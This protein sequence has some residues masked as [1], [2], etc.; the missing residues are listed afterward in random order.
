MAYSTSKFLSGLVQ[1]VFLSGVVMFSCLKSSFFK[2]YSYMTYHCI[3]NN[4]RNQ[5]L[6]TK[7]SKCI[8][9]QRYPAWKLVHRNQVSKFSRICLKFNNLDYVGV[10]G[11]DL[12]PNRETLYFSS[13]YGLVLPKW[14]QNESS[15]SLSK[16]RSVVLFYFLIR[17]IKNAYR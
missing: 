17:K 6:P 12:S 7:C 16:C 8:C 9:N 3:H 2:V 13:I 1:G 10:I 5:I 15:E 11:F 4:W 14:M